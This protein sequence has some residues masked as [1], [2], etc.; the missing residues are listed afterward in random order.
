MTIPGFLLD[1]FSWDS[2]YGTVGETCPV[3]YERGAGSWCEDW[4]HWCYWELWS[5]NPPWLW[6]WE[7]LDFSVGFWCFRIISM[8]LKFREMK[9]G[10]HVHLNYLKY[11][12]RKQELLTVAL[13]DYS[14]NVTE[15]PC[16]SMDGNWD[17]PKYWA[18]GQKNI[19]AENWKYSF[20]TRDS[21]AFL[22]D[23]MCNSDCRKDS[24]Y[25]LNCWRLEKPH[26]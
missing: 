7:H 26:L 14:G 19:T 24:K 23:C 10:L 4:A 6:L 3:P 2:F 16:Y 13:Q 12:I 21:W 20:L 15:F 17:F 11:D 25:L 18:S 1:I 22:S 5:W 9:K 8:G